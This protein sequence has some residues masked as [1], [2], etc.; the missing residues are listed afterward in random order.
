MV[1]KKDGKYG[2]FNSVS[3]TKFLDENYISIEA[4]GDTYNEG[5]IT[6]DVN[7]KS[8]ACRSLKVK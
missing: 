6:T 8:R 2:L 3:K 7:G 1:I 4:F 5:Y